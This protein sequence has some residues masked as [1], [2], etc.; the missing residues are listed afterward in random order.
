LD[1][2]VELLSVLLGLLL[3]L[4]VFYN[5]G[6]VAGTAHRKRLVFG[7]ILFKIVTVAVFIIQIIIFIWLICAVECG[8]DLIS[9]ST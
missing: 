2:S 9:T 5:A 1:Y 6:L 4:I 7:I 3:L 8:V